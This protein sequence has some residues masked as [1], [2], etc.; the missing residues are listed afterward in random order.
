[1]GRVEVKVSHKNIP[2]PMKKES[3]TFTESVKGRFVSKRGGDVRKMLV[4]SMQMPATE[5]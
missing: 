4:S 2:L 1:V 3:S 5:T